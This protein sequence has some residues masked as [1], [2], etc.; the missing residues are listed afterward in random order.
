[1]DVHER[2]RARGLLRRRHEGT[3]GLDRVHRAR[4]PQHADPGAAFARA[5]AHHHRR[6]DRRTGGTSRSSPSR[7]RSAASR[8]GCRE[9]GSPASWATRC[10]CGP[11][12]PRRCGRRSSRPAPGPYGVEIIEAIRVETGMIVTGYDY[13]EHERS[14]VRP[15]LGPD[16]GARRRGR[17]HGQGRS[18]ATIAADPPNRF[19]TIKLEQDTLPEYGAALTKDGEDV[20]VLTSPALSPILGPLGLAII[21]TDVAVDGTQVDVAMP[22]GSTQAGTSTCS[23][24]TTRRRHGLAPDARLRT[25]RTGGHDDRGTPLAAAR[26]A[27]GARRRDARGRT[28]G[29]G[30]CTR[31]PT[32][33]SSTRPSAPAPGSGTC[34]PPAS[35]R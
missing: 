25:R 9:P 17:V 29:P 31:A 35:T 20:G 15:G 34:S 13:D 30:R 4:A 23:R 5:D 21:R 8:P 10:S 26:L 33:S 28:A 22:D 19:K 18:C 2:R 7:S 27:R 14:P 32:R 11:S 1:M 16:G 12:T 6:A 3:R 24:S